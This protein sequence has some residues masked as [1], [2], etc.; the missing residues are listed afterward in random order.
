M[1]AASVLFTGATLCSVL[2]AY[3]SYPVLCHMTNLT[4]QELPCNVY[5]AKRLSYHPAMVLDARVAHLDA[6]VAQSLS[7]SGWYVF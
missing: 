5:I 3:R 1:Y 7:L 6:L 2:I 4:K